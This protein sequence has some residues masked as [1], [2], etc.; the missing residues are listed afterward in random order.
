WLSPYGEWQQD[1]GGVRL[2]AGG[3]AT[4]H[5]LPSGRSFAGEPRLTIQAPVAGDVDLLVYGGGYS[6][7]PAIW[8]LSEAAV[9]NPDLPPNYTWGGGVGL[10]MYSMSAGFTMDVNLYAAYSPTMAIRAQTETL[11]VLVPQL[12]LA[13]QDVIPDYRTGRGAAIGG[14][15]MVRLDP[16]ERWFGWSA[17]TMNRTW[18]WLDEGAAFRSDRDQPFGLTLAGGAR[19][20]EGWRATGRLRVA[21]GQPFT[22]ISPIYNATDDVWSGILG[23][24]NSDRLPW[25][26]QLD[27]RIEKTWIRPRSERILYLDLFNATNAR[28]PLSVEFS[29]DFTERL[30]RRYVPIIPNLG[31]EVTF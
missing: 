26:T 4:A 30:T 1:V 21:T 19:F 3:R 23:A 20:G 10:K 28:T 29:A 2:T 17:V 9:G 14:D 7:R 11:E 27:L 8:R 12:P 5:L 13:F 31:L 6:Q 18:R 22:P 15:L 25:F 24:P 16:R